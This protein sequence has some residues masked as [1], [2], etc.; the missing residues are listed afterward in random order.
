MPTPSG[1]SLHD[2][3][4]KNLTA[5]IQ[6]G[7]KPQGKVIVSG[8]KNA[9]TRLLAAALVADE[10]V[11]LQNFPTELVDANYKFDFICKSGGVH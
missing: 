7:Q 3:M 4:K 5:I 10:K 1:I 9:A 8:A 11:T 2:K 6:G